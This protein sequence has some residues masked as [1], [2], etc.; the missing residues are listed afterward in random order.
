MWNNTNKEREEDDELE[1]QMPTVHFGI[2]E[3]K[4]EIGAEEQKKLMQSYE[5]HL[6]SFNGSQQSLL[7]LQ[8]EKMKKIPKE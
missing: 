3:V 1:V 8:A 2:F 6:D 5:A 4:V 7:R